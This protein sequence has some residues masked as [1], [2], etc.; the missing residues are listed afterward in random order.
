MVRKYTMQNFFESGKRVTTR[1]TGTPHNA[2]AVPSSK[3]AVSLRVVS[4]SSFKKLSGARVGLTL[5]QIK[6]RTGGYKNTWKLSLE[7]RMQLS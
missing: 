2:A 3:A 6:V 4:K 7:S 5:T 1:G